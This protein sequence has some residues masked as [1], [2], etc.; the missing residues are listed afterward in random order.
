MDNFSFIN[1]RV[2]TLPWRQKG[3]RKEFLAVSGFLPPHF[4]H[5]HFFG[6]HCVSLL[7]VFSVAPLKQEPD[8]AFQKL[9]SIYCLENGRKDRG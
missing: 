8:T 3:V 9:S 4:S 2:I 1:S 6:L 7:A 5:R